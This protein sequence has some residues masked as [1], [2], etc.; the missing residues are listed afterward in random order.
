MRIHLQIEATNQIVPFDHQPLLVGTIHKWLGENAEHGE[1]SLYSFSRLERGK[2]IKNG[3]KFNMGASFFISSYDVELI[4]KMVWG[5]QQDKTMFCGFTVR[6]IVLEQDPDL[7]KREQF[8]VASP[9]FIKRRF[10]NDLEHILYTD[11]RAPQLLK[12]TLQT[13][14]KLA[15]IS[16]N[17]FEIYF[18]ASHT[19]AGTKLVNYKGIMN[20]ASWCSVIIKGSPETKLFAWNVGIGNSTGIGF[21]AIK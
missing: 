12:E 2:V 3:L 8:F 10:E 15:G 13:K 20:R 7:S 21:G 17:D 9:I 6:E 4:K 1:V 19:K 14:M 11:E 16:D 5:I 18:D